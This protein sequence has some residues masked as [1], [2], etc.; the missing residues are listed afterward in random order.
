MMTGQG[1]HE[2]PLMIII[3][4]EAPSDQDAFAEM[5]DFCKN[6]PE[7]E[8]DYMMRFTTPTTDDPWDEKNWYKSNPAL[9]KFLNLDDLRQAAKKAEA[10]PGQRANF[11][12]LR[13]NQRV[14]ADV[15][16]LS[17][18]VWHDDA[19][20]DVL[21]TFEDLRDKE[22]SLGIDLSK[23]RDLTCVSWNGYDAENDLYITVPSFFLPKNAIPELQDRDKVD[24]RKWVE[25]E[26]LIA[27]PGE[28]M[29]YE[30]VGEYMISMVE[31]YN[32]LVSTGGFDPWRRDE[33]NQALNRIGAG[34]R[35]S[36]IKDVRQGFLSMSPIVD[37]FEQLAYEKKIWHGN[38][39]ILMWNVANCVVV[40]DATS[41][42]KLDKQRSYGKIDGAV[43]TAMGLH[44][45]ITA[46]ND[47]DVS[48]WV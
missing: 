14:D 38:H 34:D 20:P 3:S 28:S 1:A 2:N 24:Y 27:C 9:G 35:F 18:N 39:P 32:M 12:N 36:T 21:P 19:H 45:L 10:M 7:S 25:S 22:V 44:A 11:F 47:Q 48:W 4:T 23:R 41:N 43:A 33:F 30:F 6:N 13:L 37:T 16:F 29:D 42:R 46:E 8:S 26:L 17:R 40:R 5:V 15:S 31:K